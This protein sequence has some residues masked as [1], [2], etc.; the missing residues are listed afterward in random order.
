MKNVFKNKINGKATE[1]VVNLIERSQKDQKRKKWRFKMLR[2]LIQ[3]ISFKTPLRKLFGS[4]YFFCKVCY[5]EEKYSQFR[6][7]YNIHPTFRFG[8]EGTKFYGAGK[9]YCG[10]NG[11][12]G[13]HSSIQ[14]HEDCKV[15]IGKNCAISHFVKI[16]TYNPFADYDFSKKAKSSKGDVVIGNNCWIG[17]NVFI[18]EGIKIGEN[19]VIGANSVV[20][21]DIPS[22]C[23]AAGCPAKVI[24]FKSYLSEKE[25]TDLKERW[26]DSLSDRLKKKIK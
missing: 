20:T 15:V 2:K 9:I 18:R 10:E 14:T 4:L 8:G 3:I 1:R 19:S 26:R 11:H 22:H 12:I 13:E 6:K 23:I 21:R 24:Q 17:A 5:E 7:K 25:K 16:Y